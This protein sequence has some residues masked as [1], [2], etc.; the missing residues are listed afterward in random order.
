[1]QFLDHFEAAVT[2]VFTAAWK[3]VGFETLSESERL[4]GV[5]GLG[6]LVALTAVFAE[7]RCRNQKKK[8]KMLRKAK[9]R[10]RRQLLREEIAKHKDELAQMM[11]QEQAAA[12][13]AAA[14]AAAQ[15]ID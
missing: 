8:A 6:L 10:A 5:F 7:I 15:Q 2:G 9:R 4:Y 1:M 3:V 11:R 13:V 12:A 14:T